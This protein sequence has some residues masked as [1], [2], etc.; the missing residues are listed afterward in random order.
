MDWWCIT[1]PQSCWQ[2]GLN[3]KTMDK[4]SAKISRG[5]LSVENNYCTVLQ[6]SAEVKGRERISKLYNIL[7][8]YSIYHNEPWQRET[9]LPIIRKWIAKYWLQAMP[10]SVK[11]YCTAAYFANE[12]KWE[13][14]LKIFHCVSWDMSLCWLTKGLKIA[15]L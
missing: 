5:I 14:E 10:I 12:Q 3:D 13:E 9:P 2:P 11:T 15:Q 7:Y 6:S 4:W 1:I 8:V